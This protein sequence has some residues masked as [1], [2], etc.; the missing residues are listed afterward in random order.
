MTTIIETLCNR[1]YRV[2]DAGPG[3]EHA[4]LGVEVKRTKLGFVP[5]KNARETLVRKVAARV[6]EVA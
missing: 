5:K 4:W 2:R 6:V 3:L 1:T